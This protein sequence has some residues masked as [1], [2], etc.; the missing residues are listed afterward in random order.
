MII[1]CPFVLCH[2]FLGHCIV[3]W[4]LRLLVTSLWYLLVIVLCPEIYD[5]W[6][7]PFGIFWSLYCVLRFTTSGY[8][9]LVSFGHCI[10]SWDL[11]LLLTSLWYLLVIVLSVLLRFTTSGY[12][13]LVSFGHCIVCPSEIYDFWLPPFGIF[14]SLYCLSFWDLRL[15][16]TSLWYL[17]TF[18]AQNQISKYRFWDN[19]THSF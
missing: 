1:V 6:L 5:F 11:R 17:L 14:W 4:D 8:L 12:L 19:Y 2:F 9:P 16:V 15:L 7:P 13:P 10:V 18:L 3:S